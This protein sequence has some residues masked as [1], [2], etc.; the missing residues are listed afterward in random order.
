MSPVKEKIYGI[1]ELMDEQQ[2]QQFWDL[3]CSSF[4][5]KRKTWDDIREEKPDD[6]DLAM[7]REIETD[8]D[9]RAFLSAEE[10]YKAL[11]LN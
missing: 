9:C 5:V 7:L 10:A 4:F 3:I 2:A 8:P 6:I 1:V 11:D